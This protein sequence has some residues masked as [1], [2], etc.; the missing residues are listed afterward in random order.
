MLKSL[1]NYPSEP[2]V[3]Y[4]KKAVQ[5]PAERLVTY[6]E[7]YKLIQHL[8]GSIVKCGISADEAFSYFSFFKQAGNKKQALVSFEKS[9]SLFENVEVNNETVMV[10]KPV[11]TISKQ[12]ELIKKARNEN[13][14]FLPGLLTNSIPDYL[15]ANPELKIALLTIDLDDY[16]NT[17]TAMQYFYPRLVSGGVLIMNNY[18]KKNGESVAI[19]EYFSG[20]DVFIRHFSS[21]KGPHYI[22]RD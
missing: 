19:K 11:N 10:V 13:I 16:E 7:L 20:Q 15:I 17:L 1:I 22:L 8:D 12:I 5:Q 4:K 3:L 14:E 21:D 2:S 6:F 18:H 9:S